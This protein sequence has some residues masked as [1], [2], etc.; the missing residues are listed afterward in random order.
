MGPIRKI[1][2]A[3]NKS[4]CK[5]MAIMFNAN[6]FLQAAIWFVEGCHA[7]NTPPP[8]TPQFL[9]NLSLGDVFLGSNGDPQS[10]PLKKRLFGVWKTLAWNQLARQISRLSLCLDHT[11]HISAEGLA[12]T[13]QMIFRSSAFL[14]KARSKRGPRY[15]VH[16][17]RGAC[18][19]TLAFKWI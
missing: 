4:K 13:S 1:R 5:R 6:L 8:K 16:V 19:S 17:G 18:F 14:A 11:A 3:K 10:W 9:S 2:P 7:P 12:R 15:L